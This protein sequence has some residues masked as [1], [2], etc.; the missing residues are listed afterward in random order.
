MTDAKNRRIVVVI[1]R[2]VLITAS[3]ELKYLPL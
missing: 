2:A 1:G 3:G